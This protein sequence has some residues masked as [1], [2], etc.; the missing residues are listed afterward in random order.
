MRRL[1]NILRYPEYARLAW[2]RWFIPM[3]IRQLGVDVSPTASFLG[4]P[5]VS[6]APE[7]RIRVGERV[8][9]CSNSA[10]T[11]LGVNH[12]VVLRTLRPGAVIEIGEDTGM[13]GTS[14]CAATYIS[15]GRGCL[16]GANVTITDT[17]FHAIKPENRRYN[18]RFEDIA[19]KPVRIGNNVFLGVGVIVLKGVTIGDNAVIGAGALV[20]N[21]I[22]SNFVATGNPARA[23]RSLV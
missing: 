5:I 4:M 13:S 7:S 15:I 16:I 12:A 1:L 2:W 17:D 19:T 21:D 6:M 10:H 8:S 11:A 3:R 9:L 23:V 22:P 14:I 20:V 18:I